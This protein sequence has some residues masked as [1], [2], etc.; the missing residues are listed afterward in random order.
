MWKAQFG[1]PL[2]SMDISD[3]KKVDNS[4]TGCVN[5]MLA[6]PLR[7]RQHLQTTWNP[8]VELVSVPI[9]ISHSSLWWWSWHQLPCTDSCTTPTWRIWVLGNFLLHLLVAL[10]TLSVDEERMLREEIGEQR[11][12]ARICQ[13]PWRYSALF[14]GTDRFYD[15]D[16]NFR[17]YQHPFTL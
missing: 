4:R 6:G 11:N 12:Y 9:G 1:N 2:I 16:C 17:F 7:H 15:A 13:R 8:A 5:A 3:C 10:S 14:Y